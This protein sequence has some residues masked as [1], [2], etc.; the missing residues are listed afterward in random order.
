MHN[1]IKTAFNGIKADDDFKTAL[2]AKAN[3][4]GK[5]KTHFAF[6][7]KAAVA[8]AACMLILCLGSIGCY[9]YFTP[10]TVISV[11]VNPSVELGINRFDKVISL[12]AF[13]DAG[14]KITSSVNVTH[15]NYEDAIE[16]LLDDTD[17]AKHAETEG[18]V[19]V[20]VFGKDDE[21][22]KAV[23]E[24]L[25]KRTEER[26]DVQCTRG[27]AK[28]AEEAHGNG[29]SMGKYEAYLELK[30]RD[31]NVTVDDVKGLTMRQ[32]KDRINKTERPSDK[33]DDDK[34]FKD[35]A[36]S[37]TANNNHHGHGGNGNGRGNCSNEN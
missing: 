21:K 12:E 9:L 22:G 15:M 26:N 5:Q 19:Y 18:L 13:N 2:K 16:V 6:Y 7:K 3:E 25:A 29:L 14:E 8:V 33:D 27:S 11:D 10:I 32:I 28:R 4:P 23:T 1:K 34:H 36:S 35:E 30:E 24:R 37:D 20:T 17:F 31:P